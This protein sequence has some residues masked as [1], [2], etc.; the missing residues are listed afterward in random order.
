MALHVPA[1]LQAQRAELVVAELAGEVALELVAELRGA[2]VDELA[3]EVGVGTSSVDH[4]QS[5][6]HERGAQ[7]GAHQFLGHL[8]RELGAQPDA[9]HAADQQGAEQAPVHMAQRGVADAATKVSGTA[10][11]MSVPTTRCDS[12]RGYISMISVAP[13]AP[14][15]IELSDT[16]T[17]SISPHSTVSAGLRDSG[18]QRSRRRPTACQACL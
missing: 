17:P 1:V 2:L 9:G 11:A 8:S 5:G 13:M 12:R 18:S 15:P 7:Q 3:V 16:S 10:W 6:R 4:F 14:A